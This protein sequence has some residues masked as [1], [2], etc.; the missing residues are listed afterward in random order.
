MG[1]LSVKIWPQVGQFLMKLNSQSAFCGRIADTRLQAVAGFNTEAGFDPFATARLRLTHYDR[2]VVRSWLGVRYFPPILP[3][4][5]MASDRPRHQASLAVSRR[6][7]LPT[8]AERP[9]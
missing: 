2:S 1:Q 5:V 9:R 4:L 7:I 3:L 8:A 6:R